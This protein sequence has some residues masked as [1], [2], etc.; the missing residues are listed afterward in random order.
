MNIQENINRIKQVMGLNESLDNTSWQDDEGN[1]VTLRDLLA[2]TENTP[3]IDFP[4]EQLKPY[5][6]DW[7]GDPDEM[8][9]VKKADLQ[10]PILIFVNDDLDILSIIDGHHRARKAL[11]LGMEYI[12][13]KLIPLSCLP[14]DIGK[15]FKHLNSEPE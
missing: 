8:V 14:D 9:K 7:N 6:L 1:K 5:L 13:A 2:I 15:V 11:M 4:V 10:Y 12:S 3:V